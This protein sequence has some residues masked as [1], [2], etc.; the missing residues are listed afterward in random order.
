MTIT[1]HREKKTVKHNCTETYKQIPQTRKKYINKPVYL[2][3]NKSTRKPNRTGNG[4]NE[5]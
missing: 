3:P 1:G 2:L 4:Q 5:K